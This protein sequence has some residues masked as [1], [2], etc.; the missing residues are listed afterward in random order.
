MVS[1]GEMMAQWLFHL[2]SSDCGQV[3][4]H[5][6]HESAFGLAH[7]VHPT[8]GALNSVDEVVRSAC[9]RHPRSKLPTI[10][11]ALDGAIGIQSGAIFA[12]AWRCA[13]PVFG[14]LAKDK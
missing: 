10:C 13:L 14:T 6:V 1:S 3:V 5:V 4:D 8:T 12:P 7:I 9:H 11:I 2:F